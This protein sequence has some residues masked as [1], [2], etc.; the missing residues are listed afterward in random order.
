MEKISYGLN[1]PND[2]LEKL[3][4][5]G[6]KIEEDPHPYDT[7][8]FFMTSF[9]LYEWVKHHYHGEEIIK[10]LQSA[11]SDKN[12]TPMP[13]MALNWLA[14]DSCFPNKGA[15]PLRHLYNALKMSWQITN[16]SKHYHW[17]KTNKVTAIEKEP[18]IKGWYQYFFTSTKPG[19]YIEFLGE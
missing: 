7:F 6:E 9:A 11:L 19:L 18:Q 2:L 10:S 4:F 1:H 16:A 13:K 17:Y 3:R 8:N 12:P 14:D 15:D 5:D